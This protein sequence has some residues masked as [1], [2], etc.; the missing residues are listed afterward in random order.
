MK[1][2]LKNLFSINSIIKLINPNF[3]VLLLFILIISC[4]K[5]D[6]SINGKVYYF[7][8]C[9]KY[10]T[11]A[12]I[13]VYLEGTNKKT[14]TDENG[15]FKFKNVPQGSYNIIFSGDSLATY[16]I[17]GYQYVGGINP[18]YINPIVNIYK[19]SNSKYEITDTYVRNNNDYYFVH[20][21]YKKIYTDMYFYPKITAYIGFDNNV[22][23]TNYEELIDLENIPDN[24]TIILKID[25][26]KNKTIY[27]VLYG[28][29]RCNSTYFDENNR[30]IDNSV[31][32]P[33]NI[34]RVE[35]D[36]QN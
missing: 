11:K 10:E 36:Y 6:R 5:E 15:N 28:R 8:S 9:L 2:T 13:K 31:G 24:S 27:L 16:K 17:I 33:S 26:Y 23:F 22:S 25:K 30:I 1:T 20:I 32:E 12:G 4:N 14:Y 18:T 35:L 7:T 29:N 3:L 21:K 19:K 34:V